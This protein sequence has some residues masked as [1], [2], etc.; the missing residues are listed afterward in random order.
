MNID[1]LVMIVVGVVIG[2]AVC[3]GGAIY[4]LVLLRRL[5]QQIDDLDD[6]QMARQQ[7]LQ[8][9]LTAI[10]ERLGG[11]SGPATGAGKP[12]PVTPPPPAAVPVTPVTPVMPVEEDEDFEEVEI[13]PVLAHVRSTPALAP[14]RTPQAGPA[15][16]P[17]FPSSPA[18]PPAS[19][20][21]V[22]PVSEVELRAAAILGRIWSWIVVGEAHRAQGVTW[23]FA[24]ATNWLMRL[25]VLAFLFFL[26]FFVKYSIDHGFFSPELRVAVTL[27]G[28]AGLVTVGMRLAG[29]RYD[30]LGMGLAGAGLAAFYFGVFASCAYYHFIEALPAFALMAVVTVGAGF[31][32]V[33]LNSLF[34]ALIGLA[35]GY[36]T[37]VLVNTGEKNLPGLFAYLL[38]LGAGVLVV[39]S[40]RNWRLLTFFSMAA[41]WGLYFVALDRFYDKTLPADFAVALGFLLAYF[42]LFSAVAFIYGL[43]RGEK[44]SMVEV[45]EML[46]NAGV[47]GV[48]GINLVTGAHSREWAALL[49]AGLSLFY[50]LHIW[51]F[52]K[53]RVQDRALLVTLTMLAAVFLAVTLPLLIDGRWLTL[54][55]AVQ[56]LAM[57]WA[58]DKLGSRFLRQLAFL[59]YLVVFGRL[60]LVDLPALNQGPGTLDFTAWLKQF[61]THLVSFGGPLLALAGG[62]KLLR[63]QRDKSGAAAAPV[64]TENDVT[65]GAPELGVG[66]LLLG[67]CLGGA[68][69][70]MQVELW[71]CCGIFFLPLRLPALSLGFVLA[72]GLALAWHLRTGR[73]WALSLGV[74]L[75]AALVLKLLCVDLMSWNPIFDTFGYHGA[76]DG[77]AVGMRAL[78]FGAVCLFLMWGAFA[79]R[80]SAGQNGEPVLAG[81]LAGLAALA[82][83]FIWLTLE[84]SEVLGQFLPGLRAG[85]VSILWA[86]FAISL[87]FAG[88]RASQRNLRVAGLVLFAVVFAKVFLSDLDRLDAI[89]RILAL[90]VVALLLGGGSFLYLRQSHKFTVKEPSP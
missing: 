21:P 49:T 60:A 61:A 35:G 37:P 39:T 77:V 2:V 44:L 86:L 9:Q 3:V 75:A 63:N 29:R 32:A 85:G 41:T 66:G 81:R 55:W 72:A 6:R 33:R 83:L 34:L 45:F 76:F 69:L 43:R 27:A 13:P 15:S 19:P 58:A 50:Q 23:E 51:L 4:A 31:L 88:I 40:R 48:A 78:D 74:M 57:L 47:T 59:V 54:A 11:T 53:R 82:L 71:H 65:G 38:L 7:T 46:I 5:G 14:L 67:I 80:R 24:F 84:V 20:T 73:P 90:F 12:S 36:L 62:W 56:A 25:G 28:G 52:L 22:P 70:L 18:V 87:L 26:G 64:T 30:L 89:Y 8:R 79:L 10:Q 16:A 1:G 17:S 68:F 42:V